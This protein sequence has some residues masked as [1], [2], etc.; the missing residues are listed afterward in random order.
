MIG[1]FFNLIS[2]C[3]NTGNYFNKNSANEPNQLGDFIRHGK[4]MKI[5]KFTFFRNLE[6]QYACLKPLKEFT[7]SLQKFFGNEKIVLQFSRSL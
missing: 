1:N 5:L 7:S 4:E 6:I 3:S 2:Q